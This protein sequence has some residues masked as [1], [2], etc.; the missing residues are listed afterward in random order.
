MALVFKSTGFRDARPT[1]YDDATPETTY[2]PVIQFDGNGNEVGGGGSQ[3]SLSV[4][5]VI[6]LTQ[7][8]IGVGD[9][10]AESSISGDYILDSIEMNFTTGVN[11]D[12]RVVTLDGTTIYELLAAG[13]QSVSLSDIDQAFDSGDN[14][15]IEVENA[16]GACT[17]TVVARVRQ[18]G[19]SGAS[20]S[21]TN[22]IDLSQDLI[23]VGDVS[24]TT[25]I[26]GDYVLDHIE[27]NFSTT[28]SRD[29]RVTTSDG[30][31]L[32][33][34]IGN[35]N[36]DVVLIDIFHGFDSGDNFTVE[37]ENAAGACVVEVI[38]RIHQGVGSDSL[39]SVVNAIESLAFDVNAAAFSGT[40]AVSVPFVLDSVEFNFSS[41]ESRDVTVTSFDGTVIYF[42]SGSTDSDISLTDLG[43][44]FPGGENFTVD[45][46]QTAGA[47]TVDV[48]ARIRQ[49]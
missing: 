49:G 44:S 1:V 6:D 2:V 15:T 22:A 30:T 24:A 28:A 48:V 16:A 21:V 23:G 33:E 45:V 37:V 14:F 35:A 25:A 43:M 39:I 29:I 11:K 4:V 5:N 13:N 36:L 27:F 46:T 32:Y 9:I 19:S 20:F 18:S 40:S 34:S 41:A 38:A 31:V 10:S 17:A 8:L 42:V 3:G 47:C 12:I 7:D 26:T